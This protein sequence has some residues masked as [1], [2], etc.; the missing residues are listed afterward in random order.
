MSC[1]ESITKN[2][3]S[4]CATAG[5][6]GLETNAWI[7]KRTDI[8]PTYSL[9]AGKENVLTNIENKV[10]KKGI[11]VTG[12]RKLFNETSKGQ[13]A[14]NRP[15]RFIHTFSFEVFEKLAADWLNMDQANDLVVITETR[16]KSTTGEG[17]FHVLG[18]VCGLYSDGGSYDANANNGVR[19][20]TLSTQEG[21]SEPFGMNILFDTDYATT[22]A[23]AESLTIVGA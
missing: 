1:I 19:T 23:I 13:V 7:V 2:V 16:D 18:I 5:V 3:I 9:V 22:L 17:V 15:N 4:T 21:D 11:K 10:G 6:G 12:I 20:I 14:T 8:T